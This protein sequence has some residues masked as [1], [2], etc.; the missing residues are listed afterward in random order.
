MCVFSLHSTRGSLS[1]A[2]AGFGDYPV[3]FQNDMVV[4]FTV[5]FLDRTRAMNASVSIIFVFK[6]GG[7]SVEIKPES[8]EHRDFVRELQRWEEELVRMSPILAVYFHC[9]QAISVITK[10]VYDAIAFVPPIIIERPL[11]FSTPQDRPNC[12]VVDEI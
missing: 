6:Q 11:P 2:I 9:S 8:T 1:T 12:W 4:G 3:R 5:V 10:Q 7:E